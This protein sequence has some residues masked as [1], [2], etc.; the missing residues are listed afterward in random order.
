M[1]P[2]L[3]GNRGQFLASFGIIYLAIG[4]T[5]VFVEPGPVLRHSMAWMPEWSSLQV[6][7]IAWAAA[8]LVA[9][10]FAF[11][12]IPVDRF[13]FMALSAWSAAWSIAWALSWVLGYNPRG[14]V[15][16]LIF[17]VLTRAVMIVAGMR[18]PVARRELP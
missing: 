8:G 16:V 15:S 9:M 6:C 2:H 1:T 3:N 12:P 7:G 11:T 14:F 5:Y 17:A 10:V 4:L 13:G 18:N